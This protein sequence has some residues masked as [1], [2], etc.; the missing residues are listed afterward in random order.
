MSERTE[1]LRRETLARLD[2]AGSSPERRY[3]WLR[4]WEAFPGSANIRRRGEANGYQLA[5]MTPVIHARELI[6]GCPSPRALTAEEQADWDRLEAAWRAVA[7]PM[8]GQASHMA[9]DYEKLLRK[10]LSGIRAEAEACKNALDLADPENLEKDDFYAGC[11]AAL[12]GLSAYARHYSEAAAA[13]AEAETDPAR[14]AELSEIARV[15]AKVPERPAQ[16]FR[17]ALQSVHFVT[18]SLVGLYQLGRPDRYLLPYYRRDLEAGRLT[19]EDALEL[20]TCQGILFNDV[21]ARGLAVG[22]MVGGT[23]AEGRDVT[24]ELTYL[25]IESIAG[26]RMIYPGVGLCRTKDTPADL[27]LNACRMLSK[28]YS[29]PAIFNDTVIRRGL[30][31]L[32]VPPE[33]SCEYIHSTCVE[34]TPCR[35]SAVWVASPY[36][37]LTQYLLDV[38]AREDIEAAAPD[39]DS[40][41]ALYRAELAR[42]VREECIRQNRLQLAR[43]LH[44]GDPLVSCFVDDCLAR[45]RDVDA[46][47]A[48]YNWIMPSFVGM[49]NLADSLITLKKLV[50]ETLEYTIP[51]LYAILKADFAGNEP[52]RQRILK[53]LPK[54]GNDDPEADAVACEIPGWI[55]AEVKKYATWRGSVFVP[56][57]F[58]WVMHERFGRET[59]ASPDG[60]PA[61]FPMGDGSGPAQ[62]RER[63]G[64]TAS[65]I[66]STKWAHWP[67]IGGIAVNLRFAAMS[68]ENLPKLAALLETYLDRGGFEVQV[69]TVDRAALAD[70]QAHP[71]RHADLVVRICGYSDY[72]TRIGKNMQD[73]VILRTAHG[74]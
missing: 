46:G 33:H 58:C 61:G 44:G 55:T 11:L 32:G 42:H 57:L 10:G 45:G 8:G 37:N 41:T 53:K 69:N 15:T 68:E 5:H 60:R 24:N 71:E 34:I 14:R 51:Q 66:S 64:S 38:L 12:D 9:I 3:L 56:S 43:R 39:Y 16:T 26:V 36:H 19:R 28:G 17:E 49:A 18:M 59:M 22:L 72:F 20:I 6:V 7:P 50:Y 23:D 13:L 65:V 74:I 70:A 63:S 31:A 27:L 29:H 30:E 35:R 62:G 2:S 1:F 48:V 4:G 73:E 52:L 40:L 67:F 21:I 47:G 54:Y 25:F